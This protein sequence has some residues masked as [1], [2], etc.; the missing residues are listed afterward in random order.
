MTAA[1]RLVLETFGA[2]DDR[3]RG[4]CVDIHVVV[5][6]RGGD[7]PRGA[8]HPPRRPV[9]A[10]EGVD[11]PDQALGD[12]DRRLGL[13]QLLAELRRPRPLAALAEDVDEA[14]DAGD[15]G[16]GVSVGAAEVERGVERFLGL[17]VVGAVVEDEAEPLVELCCDRGE[18]VLERQGETGADRLQALVEVAAL[19]LDDALQAEDAGVEVDALGGARVGGGEP[20]QLDRLRVAGAAA[21]VVGHREPFEGGLGR[22]LGLGESLGCETAGGE[23]LFPFAAELVDRRQATLRLGVSQPVAVALAVGGELAPGF[24]R[25]AELAD[26]LGAAAVALQRLG[27]QFLT[28]VP[29]PELERL[30]R[31]PHRV[32][33]G[34]DRLGGLCGGEQSLAG[35]GV[36]AGAA[37]VGGDLE[38]AATACLQGL[39]QFAMQIPAADP[40][41]LGVERLLGQCVAEAGRPRPVFLQQPDLDQLGQAGVRG[42]LGGQVEIDLLTDDGGGLGGFPGLGREVGDADQHCFADRVG[43][44]DLVALGK[45][46]A[47]SARTQGVPR[48]Q[49]AD[50]LLDEEGGAHRPVVDRP[51]QRRGGRLGQQLAQQFADRGAIERLERQLLEL[52][53]AAQLVAQ[54]AEPV[55]AGQAVGAVGGDDQDRQLLQRARQRRQELE[56]G[57]V[58]PLQVVEDDHRR[59]RLAEVGEGAAD[60]LEDRRPFAVGGGLAELGEQQREVGEERAALG[61]RVGVRPQLRA[62]RLDDRAVGDRGPVGRGSPEG[63]VEAG[64]DLGGEGALADPRLAG[65]QDD[66]AVALPGPLGRLVQLG[67][68]VRPS[69]QQFSLAH[70]DFSLGAGR[71]GSVRPADA[72][73]F[74]KPVVYE[75]ALRRVNG[76]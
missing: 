42:E 3:Q 15:L 29:G 31:R 63:P 24:R 27:P 75:S 61:E 21:M 70:G 47:T 38:A 6:D 48:V 71:G 54:P 59:R 62:Q 58:R 69:D 36:A 9:L 16:P 10:F 20:G 65:Q 22:P 76:R 26:Q 56:R 7:R 8:Q 13:D 1:R 46:E 68:L 64:G 60:R 49:R 25:F 41:H 19:G 39:G 30:A 40:G 44:R 14:G 37:P 45:L 52:A 35:A 5:A 51:H 67:E 73:R 57:L 43:D 18:V 33:V 74:G 72:R 32:A 12:P 4:R 50:Q 55:V 23:G 11:R 34:V 53:V 28:L 2:G 66:R 17:A